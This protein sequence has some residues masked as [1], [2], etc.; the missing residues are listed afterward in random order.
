MN[1]IAYRGRDN[2]KTV[3]NIRLTNFSVNL[4]TITMLNIMIIIIVFEVVGNSNYIYKKTSY[5]RLI[6]FSCVFSNVSQR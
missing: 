6:T 5:S 2:N 1:R 4:F 3:Y